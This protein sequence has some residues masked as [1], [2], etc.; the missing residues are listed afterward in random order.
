MSSPHPLLK[1]APAR[2][3]PALLL[4]P[5]APELRLP[6]ARVHEVCGSARTR[7]AVWIAAQTTGPVIWIAPD[8]ARNTPNPC[9][10]SHLIHP[11]RLI[12]VTPRRP[13][14]ILWCMEEILRAGAIALAVADLPDLPNLTQIR[15]MHLAAETGAR[16]GIGVSPIG[17]LLT[18]HNG[19]APGVETRWHLAPDHATRPG[20]W[21]LDRLRARTAPQ[22]H[23]ILE[24][25]DPSALPR[26]KAATSEK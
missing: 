12:H 23:W 5:D 9:G 16:D 8:W 19:G 10:L 6:F 26:L 13:E 20:Q 7:F 18:S 25:S 4:L 1:R 3:A 15:R 14:D 24:Q 11:S 22:A 17:L 21:R 2:A